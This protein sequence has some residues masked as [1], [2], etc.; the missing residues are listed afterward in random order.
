MSLPTLTIGKT[1]CINSP[2]GYSGNY[3]LSEVNSEKN[4]PFDVMYMFADTWGNKVGF[5]NRLFNPRGIKVILLLPQPPPPLPPLPPS[6][7][8][9]MPL[10]SEQQNFWDNDDAPIEASNISTKSNINTNEVHDLNKFRLD[11]DLYI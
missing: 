6:P 4:K 3:T 5:I 7:P 2:Y 11:E 9:C 8:K 10:P 1:Y